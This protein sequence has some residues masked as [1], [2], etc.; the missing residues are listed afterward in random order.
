MLTFVD[1]K[2]ISIVPVYRQ[3]LEDKGLLRAANIPQIAD[4]ERRVV[5]LPFLLC[6]KTVFRDETSKMFLLFF[7]SLPKQFKLVARSSRLTVQ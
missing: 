7:Y 2:F 1:N 6:F 4:V 3:R 5:L